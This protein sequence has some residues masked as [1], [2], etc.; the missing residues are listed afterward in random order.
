[1]ERKHIKRLPVVQG[2][3]IV[4]IVRRVNLIQAFATKTLFPGTPALESAS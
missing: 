2:N 3:K 4:G 1:M